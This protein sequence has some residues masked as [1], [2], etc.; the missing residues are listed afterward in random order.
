MATDDLIA[1]ARVLYEERFPE[2]GDCHSVIVFKDETAWV[3]SGQAHPCQIALEVIHR[4]GDL[5]RPPWD[6]VATIGT[7]YVET[8]DHLDDALGRGGNL[9]ENPTDKT[10]HCLVATCRDREGKGLTVAWKAD[11]GPDGI[12]VDADPFTMLDSPEGEIADSLT[13]L[14]MVGGIW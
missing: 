11:L 9:Q 14:G 3:L 5:P 13:A 1:Q 2:Y 10:Y 4:Q 12:Q 7:A 6:G 8:H